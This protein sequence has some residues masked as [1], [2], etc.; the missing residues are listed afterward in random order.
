MHVIV[1]NKCPSLLINPVCRA[2]S[3][4]V[5]RLRVPPDRVSWA[6][7]TVRY[8]LVAAVGSGISPSSEEGETAI[9]ASKG[10][11]NDS[12]YQT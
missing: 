9:A 7:R 12:C 4:C 5:R 10:P 11:S 3:V 2:D 6:D 8:I 1:Y